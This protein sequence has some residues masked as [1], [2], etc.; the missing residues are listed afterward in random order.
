MPRVHTCLHTSSPS[1]FAHT[2]YCFAC[3]CKRV[4]TP[5][6]A[7][8][9]PDQVTVLNKFETIANTHVYQNEGEQKEAIAKHAGLS[10]SFR[11][12]R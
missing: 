6:G 5:G 7:F 9:I 8:K 1:T 2:P 10:A 4:L 12:V 11:Y 3:R